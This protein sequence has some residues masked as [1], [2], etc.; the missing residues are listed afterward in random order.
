EQVYHQLLQQEAEDAENKVGELIADRV[1]L[2]LQGASPLSPGPSPAPSE[3]PGEPPPS[4]A[5]PTLPSSLAPPP[6]QPAHNHAELSSVPPH[7]TL[8]D[9]PPLLF[10]PAA[11]ARVDLQDAQ[12]N[13][14]KLHTSSQPHGEDQIE[15]RAAGWARLWRPGQA[16]AEQRQGAL[17][18]RELAEARV[19][20]ADLL[21]SPWNLLLWP[22]AGVLRL[23]VLRRALEPA[24]GG[25]QGGAWLDALAV[26]TARVL[27]LAARHGVVLPLD[28]TRVARGPQGLVSLAIPEPI[29]RWGEVVVLPLARWLAGAEANKSGVEQHFLE[30]VDAH[31]SDPEVIVRLDWVQLY[32]QAKQGLS[33]EAR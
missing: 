8:P 32:Q 22:G 27:A 33:C 25:E 4:E 2:Q 11:A 21:P 29:T 17:A 24:L 28:P 5:P 13:E 15:E 14:W 7:G 16:F 10:W 23:V 31:L 20:A 3:P 12:Q 1:I 9:T 18:L 19:A 30:R 6:L 26:Y